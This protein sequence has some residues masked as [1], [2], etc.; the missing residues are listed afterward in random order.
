M[1][2]TGQLRSSFRANA[3]TAL[4]GRRHAVLIQSPSEAEFPE[5]PQNALEYDGQADFVG[6]TDGL[7]A[8]ILR[9]V[10]IGRLPMCVMRQ[11]VRRISGWIN[12]LGLLVEDL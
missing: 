9:L 10:P 4:W 5:M 2:A 11:P 6:P 1:S 8:E 12:P 3:K 7:A